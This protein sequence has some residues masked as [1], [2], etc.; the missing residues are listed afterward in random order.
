MVSGRLADPVL[1]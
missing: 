1:E